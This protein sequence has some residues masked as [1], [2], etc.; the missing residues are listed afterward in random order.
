MSVSVHSG[1]SA[2]G[3][4][5]HYGVVVAVVR[6]GPINIRGIEMERRISIVSFA[7]TYSPNTHHMPSCDVATSN[8]STKVSK[9]RVLI[10]GS[11]SRDSND[12]WQMCLIALEMSGNI[13]VWGNIERLCPTSLATRHVL[14]QRLVGIL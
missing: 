7:Y 4:R 9:S 14:L 10:T 6:D 13:V 5:L 2:A 3:P 1:V 8:Y 12:I 11:M